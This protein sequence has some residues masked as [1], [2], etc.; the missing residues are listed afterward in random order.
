MVL[1]VWLRMPG[2]LNRP[3][4]GDEAVQAMKA[5]DMLEGTGYRYDPAEFHG[6]LLYYVAAGVCRA[7][8]ARTGAEM[9]EFMVRCVPLA[10]G[11]FLV[12][13]PFGFRRW[14]GL[15]GAVCAG[16][17][18]AVS[19][20]LVFQGG[21]F[22][23]ESLLVAAC[24]SALLAWL[25]LGE[26]GGLCAR[27]AWA[28]ALGISLGLAIS[29]KETALI[30][31][32]AGVIGSLAAGRWAP[33]GCRRPARE[34]LPAA[35]VATATAAA[36]TALFYSS[37]GD[38]PGGIADLLRSLP[39]YLARAGGA[40]TQADHSAPW[41]EVPR[42][43][44][45]YR[46]GPGPVWG[47]WSTVWFAVAGLA[48]LF[49]PSTGHVRRASLFLSVYALVLL[50][51]YGAIPYKT[52]WLLAGPVHALTLV[53]GF[54][55]TAVG[56]LPRRRQVAAWSVGA[57]LVLQ[58]VLLSRHTVGLFGADTRNPHVYAHSAPDVLRLAARI[59][60]LAASAPEGNALGIRVVGDDIWPLPWYLRRMTRTLYS[61]PRDGETDVPVVIA[62]LEFESRLEPEL[63]PAYHK[64]F[65]GLRPEVPLVVFT[66]ADSWDRMMRVGKM[67]PK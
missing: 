20:C 43:L 5:A 53:A 10:A 55:P 4:H 34:R 2:I 9:T 62:N 56:R 16:L 18:A 27:M 32:G 60:R 36:V 25:R 12:I 48:C 46:A 15:D 7:S 41:H 47:E 1:A 23:Q 22:I 57:A 40:G 50:V 11:I 61:A 29:C 51:V 67:S 17:L 58:S 24:G 44:L 63:E 8:G 33:G 66:R 39:G 54:A 13:L 30:A 19:P 59:G 38:H 3:M 28:G 31:L 6:P 35:L 65:F 26:A 37:L 64:E 52:P 21:F 14:F 49:L 45:W 42:M